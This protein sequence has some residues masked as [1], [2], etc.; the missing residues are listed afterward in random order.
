MIHIPEIKLLSILN[1][2]IDYTRNDTSNG[3]IRQEETLLYRYF[4]GQKVGDWDY[5]EKAVEMFK[6]KKSHPRYLEVRPYFD[7]ERASIPT[8]H[9]TM[10][11]DRPISDGIGVDEGYQENYFDEGTNRITPTLT[12]TFEAQHQIIISS[13]NYSEVS[14]LYSYVKAVLISTLA[15][16]DLDGLQNPRLGGQDLMIRDALVPKNI[17]Y[18]AITITSNHEFHV[19]KLLSQ[20]LLRNLILS[21]KPIS[22]VQ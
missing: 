2:L 5:Y 17:F 3:S 20:P 8:I 22:T 15:E 1:N 12:R 13:D 7:T 6:R 21:G 10:P 19:P 11:S 16:I 18:K 14:M 9:L 4:F